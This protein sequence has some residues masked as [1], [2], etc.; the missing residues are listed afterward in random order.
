LIREVLVEKRMTTLTV[1]LSIF[2]F[3][4]RLGFLVTSRRSTL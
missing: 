4:R 1:D 2:P 3:R